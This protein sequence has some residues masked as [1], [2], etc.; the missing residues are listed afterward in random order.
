MSFSA[1]C[2]TQYLGTCCQM[3]LFS[4]ELQRKCQCFDS[5]H[6]CTTQ[7]NFKCTLSMKTKHSILFFKIHSSL[8]P[9]KKWSLSC[10][11]SHHN[12]VRISLLSILWCVFQQWGIHEL[13]P[14]RTLQKQR[15]CYVKH[16]HFNE[17]TNDTHKK[18]KSWL[19]CMMFTIR[20][21]VVTRLKSCAY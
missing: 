17:G 21:L 7:Y 15:L 11:Y 14:L 4:P 6:L 8:T 3:K 12:G 16:E 10:S 5:Q 2:W 19:K 1:W 20:I 9:S 18:L 13:R